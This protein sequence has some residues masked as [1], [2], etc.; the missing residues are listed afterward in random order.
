MAG[1]IPAILAVGILLWWRTAER[2]EPAASPA[3]SPQRASQYHIA[4]VLDSH[5]GQH[6]ESVSDIQEEELA[7]TEALTKD[8]PGRDTPLSLLATV[9]QY[10]GD[11]TE[12]EALWKQ[13]VAL[14]PR[15][16]DLYEKLGEAARRKDEL[17]EAIAWWQKGLEADPQAPGLRWEIANARVTQGQP[18]EALAL[19]QQECAITPK[20][21]RNY[22][23]LGQVHLKQRAYEEAQA[24]YEK[25]I[26]IEPSYYNAY[27]GLGVVFTRL[28]QPEQAKAAMA[29]FRQLKTDAA[30]SE[31]KRI[32]IDEMPPARRRAATF[33]GQ[34]YSLY[35]PKRQA[36]IGQRLLARALELDPNNAY[37]WEK[38]AGHHY[39]NNR[40]QQALA[41]FQKAAELA[42]DNPLPHI[43][44]GKLYALVK[45]PEQAEQALQQA[46]ARFP[47]S[48]LAHSEL[49]LLYLRSRSR[50]AQALTL[51]QKAVAL[52]PTA[53]HYYL[54]TWAYDVNGD[55]KNALA[56]IEKAIALEP[57]NQRYRSTYER[58]RSRF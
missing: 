17:D 38:L 31:D 28:R 5:T 11:T 27:Y 29:R 21:P 42:P 14:N 9:H 18:D 40:H 54:L 53:H 26:E 13:A 12:A 48:G 30:G 6:P 2:P 16:S 15:R 58:I 49:A 44:V 39:V 43:N 51:T 52:A 23:L 46:V 50:P 1:I 41:L 47:D 45:Q 24:A 25:A 33:Y 55:L 56:T 36:E 32:M 20:A 8:F 22:Y 35:D 57:D 10:R 34:A 19:L 7:L 37:T 4:A 3:P